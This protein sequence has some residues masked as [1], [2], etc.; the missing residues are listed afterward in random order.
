MNYPEPTWPAR[1]LRFPGSAVLA[2]TKICKIKAARL[3]AS[4]GIAY[5]APLQSN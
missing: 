1:L 5:T 2:K 4:I 3:M